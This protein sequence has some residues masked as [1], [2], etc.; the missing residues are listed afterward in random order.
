MRNASLLGYASGTARG[1][2]PGARVAICKVGSE[3]G[4][5]LESDIIAAIDQAIADNVNVLSSL[6]GYPALE[7]YEDIVAIRA[8]AAMEHGIM[9]SCAGGNSVP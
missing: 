2:A 6:I 8:F 7:Y 1:M 9:I 5:I 3:R 4:N